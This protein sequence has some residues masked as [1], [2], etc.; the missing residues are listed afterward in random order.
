MQPE[1][2]REPEPDRAS[3]S[4]SHAVAAQGRSAGTGLS[5]RSR[6][7]RGLRQERRQLAFLLT[8]A[9]A[10]VGILLLVGM[11]SWLE[12]AGSAP[13]DL[14]V[15]T[16]PIEDP[17]AAL[18]PAPSSGPAP[19]TTRA[20]PADRRPASARPKRR[21]SPPPR[22]ANR[23]TTSPTSPPVV[24]KPA[25]TPAAAPPAP[26]APVSGL[27]GIE[28]GGW[29][30]VVNTASGLCLDDYGYGTTDGAALKQWACTGAVNQQWRFVPTDRGFFRVV[31]RQA[32]NLGWDVLGGPGAVPDS[33]PIHLW[34]PTGGP[35]QQWRPL[36]SGTGG[37]TF[38]VRDGARCLNVPGSGLESKV[39]LTIYPCNGSGAQSFRVKRK[40]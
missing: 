2:G 10:I 31:T 28:L 9:A 3:R 32:P 30:E 20:R 24:R 21:A 37:F 6:R 8:A 25:V 18:T 26:A 1:L 19:T 35:N 15:V 13:T 23:A 38:V 29:Y 40:A 7:S 12:G 17:D 22:A 33:T 5:R 34:H 27:P 36:P 16:P 4:R 39:Q 11:R 14:S